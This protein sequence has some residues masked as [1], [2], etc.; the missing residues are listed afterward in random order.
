M[1]GNALGV[2][3]HKLKLWFTNVQADLFV[4][5]ILKLYLIVRSDI[6]YPSKKKN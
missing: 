1:F 3:K 6:I 4:W 5:F 2:I